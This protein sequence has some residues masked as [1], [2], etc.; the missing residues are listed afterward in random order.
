MGLI[1]ALPEDV[2]NLA[3]GEIMGSQKH[4][5]TALFL[6][7]PAGHISEGT[8]RAKEKQNFIEE[9]NTYLIISNRSPYDRQN[10]FNSGDYAS[11]RFLKT[12]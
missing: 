8:N 2:S 6:M 9:A 11:V 10:N 1:L 4:G 12:K 7:N 5:S 3:Y